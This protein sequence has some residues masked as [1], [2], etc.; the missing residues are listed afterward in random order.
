MRRPCLMSPA[1]DQGSGGLTIRLA[2]AANPG[3][4][5]AG[6][7]QLLDVPALADLSEDH[8]AT[9]ELVLAEVLNNIA[10]HAY[11]AGAGATSVTLRLI[12]TGLSCQFSDCG[13]PMPGGRLPDGKLSVT[14]VTPTAD[15]PE[16][17]FG[18]HLIRSLTQDLHYTRADGQNRLAFLIPG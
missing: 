9:V 14:P 5:R 2:L 18:W 1:P 3:S 12:S 16:G 15:L 6:L 10:E 8:R 11:A 4:V 13:L 7:A 17:G